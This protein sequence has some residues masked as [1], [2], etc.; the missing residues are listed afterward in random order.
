MTMLPW[1]HHGY[2]QRLIMITKR[3]TKMNEKTEQKKPG[4]PVKNKIEKI[5]AS[6]KDIARAIFRA[7]DP[8]LWH[9]TMESV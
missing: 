5:D 3:N 8:K 4:R 1:Q 6:P 7:A 9:K 2:F